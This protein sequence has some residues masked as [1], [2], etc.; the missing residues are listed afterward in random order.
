MTDAI[1]FACQF[2]EGTILAGK[3]EIKSL[4]GT[5]ASGSVYKAKHL[6]TSKI[7]ALKVLPRTQ[8]SDTT[9]LSRFMQESRTLAS[10]THPNIV[11][12]LGL[13]LTDACCLLAMD[14]VEGRTL[15]QYLK[16][17]GPVSRERC[18][19]IFSQVMRGLSYMHEKGIIHR[20]IKPEN[21]V[22]TESENDA[23]L[24]V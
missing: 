6:A 16:D 13:E 24:R 23:P 14:Y 3:Y 7:V 12:V 11:G 21:L 8:E 15:A 18:V 10:L 22:I 20:D 1:A 9:A 17:E 2:P 4:V 5:G 19:L